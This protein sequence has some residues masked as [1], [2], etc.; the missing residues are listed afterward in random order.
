MCPPK[1]V[2]TDQHRL[3]HWGIFGKQQISPD[4][5][6]SKQTRCNT[7]G[8]VVKRANIANHSRNTQQTPLSRCS[9]TRIAPVV[10]HSKPLKKQSA[11]R[12]TPQTINIECDTTGAI[13]KR[14]SISKRSR[15]TQQT[16]VSRCPNTQFAP[17]VSHPK[18]L[19]QHSTESVK[20]HK[21]STWGGTSLGRL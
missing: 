12:E 18:P 15:N 8:A 2:N 10:S 7:T 5:E 1:Q 9:N 17:V 14:P 13:V 4:P 16:P 6:P 19:K 3:R 20:H 21:Q 11:E